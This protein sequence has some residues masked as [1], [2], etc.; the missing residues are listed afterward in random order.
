MAR[1]WDAQQEA[2]QRRAGE[3]LFVPEARR[4]L[5]DFGPDD[6]V[7]R[8]RDLFIEA[9]RS[10]DSLSQQNREQVLQDM[11][12]E[13]FLSSIGVSAVPQSWVTPESQLSS[14]LPF[15]SSPTLM[16][17]QLSLPSY[18]KLKGK[19]KAKAKQEEP[20]EQGDAVA[21]RLRKYA[22]LN[23]SPTVHGEPSLAL[24]RWDLGADPDDITWKPGQDLEAEDAINRRRR[25]IEA[26]RRK[27]ERLSQR[28]LGEDSFM[29][30]Q[31]SQSL[32]PFTKPLPTILS[33]GASSSQRLSS[34][35]GQS[36]SQSQSQSQQSGL[37]PPWDFS[38]QQQ[39]M[40][41]GGFGTPR[42]RPGS[43]LRREYRRDSGMGTATPLAQPQL[44]QG[45]PSQ[46]KSQVLP[47]LFGGRQSF[48]PF[49]RSPVKK[50]KRKSEVRLS[51]FR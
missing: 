22:A 6:L 51:G 25:R 13:L 12:A 20:E 17:S 18:H 37:V 31:L 30:D 26:R 48:S 16:S 15:P 11:A 27:A 49:K 19:D 36:Q 47:G 23:V 28:I 45:T 8:L 1:E 4:P 46:P 3:W 35:L 50:G 21:L 32:G 39:G 43:P 40:G 9:Q 34:G 10:Q 2:L 29:S 7:E 41:P 14:S 24:S 44:S 5:I 42:L 33:T 38:S